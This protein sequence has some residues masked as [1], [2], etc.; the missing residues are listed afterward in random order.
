MATKLQAPV[1]ITDPVQK[2]VAEGKFT[3][4][5]PRCELRQCGTE[6]PLVLTGAGFVDQGVDGDITLRMFVTDRAVWLEA[7]PF[8]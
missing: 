5:L 2:E 8:R 3:L 7:F 4:S 1:A 6:A